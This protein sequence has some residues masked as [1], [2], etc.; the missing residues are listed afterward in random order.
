MRSVSK[1]LDNRS[2]PAGQVKE[3]ALRVRFHI[4][5]AS[6]IIRCGQYAHLHLGLYTHVDCDPSPSSCTRCTLYS[7]KLRACV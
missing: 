3:G 2:A 7:R 5:V 4:P 6:R 1:N